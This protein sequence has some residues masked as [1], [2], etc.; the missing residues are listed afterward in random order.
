MNFYKSWIR[1]LSDKQ[2]FGIAIALSIP[3]FL[4]QLGLSAF[5]GDEAIRSLVAF[6]M[7]HSGNYFTPTLNGEPY[8]NKPP[9]FNW[10]IL[11]VSNLWG[12]FGEWPTRLTSLFFLACYAVTVFYYSRRHFDYFSSAILCLML[13]CC[14]RILFWDSMY[15]LI[16]ICFSW[17]IYLNFM[18]LFS[19][20]EKGKWKQ[21]FVISYLLC[22]IAFLLKGLP[23]MVFQAISVI[24][25]LL[26]KG[27]FRT[28]IVSWIH[29]TGALTGFI[30]LIIYYSIY[31]Y[32]VSLK[33]A[34]HI[35][36]DQSLQ[37]TVT[38][39]GIQET[40]IHLVTF[41]FEQIYHFL[42]WSLLV[43]LIFSPKFWEKIRE[44]SFI[45]FNFW[46]LM[47][48]IPV[49]WSSVQVYP[50]YLLMFVPLFNVCV[51]YVLS[52]IRKVNTSWW[53]SFKK[54][55]LVITSAAFLV[56]FMM[57]LDSRVAELANINLI[58]IG[59]SAGLFLVL[60]SMIVDHD[61]RIFLWMCL[62]LFIFRITFNGVLIP[63]RMKNDTSQLTKADCQR[64]ALQHRNQPW[65]LYDSSDTHQVARFY[66]ANFSKQ[67]I[68][69][70]NTIIDSNAYY[71]VDL[72][73]YP[74]F[75]G[76][77]I[78]SLLLESRDRL[79]LMKI[80]Q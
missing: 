63:L 3:A 46:M 52:Q 71:L 7:K 61:R 31:A 22:S 37:R 66:T 59:S 67:I 17:I 49:Y 13:L 68:Y 76:Y 33:T 23:A 41:P 70:T 58:W 55:F 1:S 64:V 65:F 56:C 53:T 45:Q 50:R 2:L 72:R 62:A 74:Q 43:F 4:Y 28:K 15:G 44:N 77:K 80:T 54:L 47:V 5:I 57:P 20:S 6:E 16:D 51:Y 8:Y 39:F 35:L 26:L 34:I 11:L 60:L 78:D 75:S 12:S 18:I 79:G 10:L 48:N 24:T 42:P 73:L 19:H 27:E 21:M 14:G 32:E 30:P 29:I 36:F 25:V 9:L 38:H 69:R 40:L